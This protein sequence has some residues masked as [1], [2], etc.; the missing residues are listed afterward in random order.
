[1][2]YGYFI[3]CF[4]V[5]CGSFYISFYIL[6]HYTYMI[7]VTPYFQTLRAQ[8]HIISIIN[9]YRC[10]RLDI[11]E[12]AQ[13]TFGLKPTLPDFYN[14]LLE[15]PRQDPGGYGYVCLCLCICKCISSFAYSLIKICMRYTSAYILLNIY[16]H[17]LISSLYIHM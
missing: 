8:F 15:R 10:E 4:F 5:N 6:I 9:I 13:E 17:I 3:T 11:I 2:V 7:C 1:M 14:I 12:Q 16:V